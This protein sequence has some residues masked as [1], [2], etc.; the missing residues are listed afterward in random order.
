MARSEEAQERRSEKEIPKVDSTA[1]SAGEV[2]ITLG[3]KD[4]TLVPSLHA[5]QVI[6]KRSNGLR[7]ALEAITNYDFDVIALIVELGLGQKVVRENFKTG[8]LAEVIYES[9]LADLTEGKAISK[10]MQYMTSLMTRGGHDNTGD[11]NGANP[12]RTS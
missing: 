4:Y 5:L 7:G 3:G 1:V 10:C 11:A 6:S 2:P 9:G 12:P 8:N